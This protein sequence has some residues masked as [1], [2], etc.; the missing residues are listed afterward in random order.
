MLPVSLP[1]RRW[2]KTAPDPADHPHDD[3]D[4]DPRDRER[5]A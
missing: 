1:L 3:I 4:E 5:E 2:L